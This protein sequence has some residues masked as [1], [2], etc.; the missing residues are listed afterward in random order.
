MGMIYNYHGNMRVLVEGNAGI[1]N[2]EYRFWPCFMGI[3]KV[4]IFHEYK[5]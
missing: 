3:S 5:Y 2:D 1:F 4:I